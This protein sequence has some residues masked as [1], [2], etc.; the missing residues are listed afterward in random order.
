MRARTIII[1]AGAPLVAC[2]VLYLR[3]AAAGA[4]DGD[5]AG[6]VPATTRAAPSEPAP[7]RPASRHIVPSRP[8]LAPVT[9]EEARARHLERAERQARE[10]A[11]AFAAD[12]RDP[13][14]SGQ[15]ELQLRTAFTGLAIDGAR[16][17]D[18]AC[19]TRLCRF[20]VAFD[21]LERRDERIGDVMGMTRWRTRSFGDASPEDPKRYVVYAARDRESFPMVE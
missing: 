7:A 11:T 2:A 8:A 5:G 15:T 20:V 13:S 10:L 16:L 12:R 21:S 6:A 14:W 18:L 9:R 17:D 19:G 1:V 4:S 3:S